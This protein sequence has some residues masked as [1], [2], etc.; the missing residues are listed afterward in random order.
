MSLGRYGRLLATEACGQP[1]HVIGRESRA[2][3]V[4]QLRV[5]MSRSEPAVRPMRSTG[6]REIIA[7]R[8]KTGGGGGRD[9]RGPSRKHA[10][11]T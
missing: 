6:R 8:P 4:V 5:Q 3:N 9:G 11:Q 7:V 10:A 1:Y 2:P